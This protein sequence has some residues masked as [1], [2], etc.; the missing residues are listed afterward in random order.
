[1]GYKVIYEAE[2]PHI[3][4]LPKT[5]AGLY[6]GSVI[7]CDECGTSYVLYQDRGVPSW[8]RRPKPS[9]DISPTGRRA[10]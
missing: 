6:H 5:D 2:E 9:R 4:D 3:C 7:E 10:R 8:I 1:M